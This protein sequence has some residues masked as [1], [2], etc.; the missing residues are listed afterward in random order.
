MISEVGE[1]FL[2]VGVNRFYCDVEA[3]GYF[4]VGQLFMEA[5]SD[6]GLPV[7]RQGADAFLHSFSQ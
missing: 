3:V 4:L 5:Q 1:S 6:D 7:G 2:H